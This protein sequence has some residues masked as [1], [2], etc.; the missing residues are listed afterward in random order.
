M[1]EATRECP[2]T[3][4]QSILEDGFKALKES[5]QAVQPNMLRVGGVTRT[6]LMIPENFDRSEIAAETRQLDGV[7][8]TTVPSSTEDLW[9]VC[10]GEQLS[11][12]GVF[13]TLLR[14]SPDCQQ[15]AA[16]LHTRIDIDW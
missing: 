4:K 6:L 10:E 3:K 11:V 13:G 15:L 9:V 12:D 1:D 16:R 5:Y 8:P 14:R 7:P 2:V